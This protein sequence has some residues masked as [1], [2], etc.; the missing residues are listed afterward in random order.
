MIFTGSRPRGSAT[1][2]A[3]WCATALLALAGCDGGAA[4]PP[5]AGGSASAGAPTVSE[6]PASAT[7]TSA[8]TSTPTPA[9]TSKS[10]APSRSAANEAVTLV[11]S[12]GLAGLAETITVQ[13]DGRW[14]LGNGGSVERT[15]RLSAAQASRLQALV[16]DPRLAAEAER[17]L[18]TTSRCNDAFTYLLIVDH[19]MVK[20]EEC[21]GQDEPPKVTMEIVA[22]LR[23]ATSS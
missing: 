1:A 5:S 4:D 2:A 3:L 18:S 23:D 6:A 13:P 21:P 12:G 22:L 19:Q 15:G 14:K 10:P 8:S 17:G 9:E 7:P 11:R 16:A 20:Y